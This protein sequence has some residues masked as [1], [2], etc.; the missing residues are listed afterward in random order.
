MQELKSYVESLKGLIV[1]SQSQN[2]VIDSRTNT[3]CTVGTNTVPINAR[4]VQPVSFDYHSEIITKEIDRMLRNIPTFKG[5][6]DENFE[7][8]MLVAEQALELGINYTEL[9][10]LNLVTVLSCT[11]AQ[12]NYVKKRGNTPLNTL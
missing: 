3:N 4:V 11:V 5:G 1:Q 10:K 7:S 2:L 6:S 12:G 8:W 9:Q